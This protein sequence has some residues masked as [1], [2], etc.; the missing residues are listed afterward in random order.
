MQQPKR[1]KSLEGFKKRKALMLKQLK[2]AED[3]LQ[4]LENKRIQV[5]GSFTMK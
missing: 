4:A 2:K 1:I 3:K 5:L